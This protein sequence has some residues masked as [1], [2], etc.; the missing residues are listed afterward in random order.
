LGDA[1]SGCQP[2][3][4]YRSWL[5]FLAWAP[6]SALPS[7]VLLALQPW[8][9]LPRMIDQMIDQMIHQMMHPMVHA[10]PCPTRWRE[11]S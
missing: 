10:W 11:S 8:L 4:P 6:R 3:R 9:L 1:F 2:Y 5:A 7:C